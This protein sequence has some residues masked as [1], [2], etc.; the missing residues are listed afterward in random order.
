LIWN[1]LIDLSKR[2]E[3]LFEEHLNQYSIEESID[4]EGWKDLFWK[5]DHIRKCHMKIIDRRNS[6]KLWLMHINIFP[7]ETS[8]IPILGFDIISGKNKITGSF[9]DFSPVCDHH[10]Y[11]DHFANVVK[12]LSWN[13]KRE[14]PDWAKSIFS[15]NIIAVGNIKDEFEINQLLEICFNLIKFYITN[16][17]KFEVDIGNFKE[18]QNFYCKQQ[19]L[20]PHLH[21]SIL[22]MGISEKEKNRYIEKI[23]FEEI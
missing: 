13:K 15:S 14:L 22:A 7:K 3:L 20:N 4:F 17:R 1:H 10:E 2:I 21:R 6:Q 11:H 12:N 19:K 8:N 18:Q 5:S 16:I 23:L 9:F